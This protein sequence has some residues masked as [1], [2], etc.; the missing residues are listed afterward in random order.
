MSRL[1]F[2]VVAFVAVLGA[3]YAL[4]RHHGY[5]S[6]EAAYVK[7]INAQAAALQSAMHQSRIEARERLARREDELHKQL[8]AQ[9]TRL[10]ELL[11]HDDDFK[12][13]YQIRA[14]TAVGDVLYLD[15]RMQQ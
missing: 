3:T 5:S 10:R 1:I 9:N 13:W 6:A 2:A 11:E 8:A 4:G 12:A 14:P 15:N 7:Q